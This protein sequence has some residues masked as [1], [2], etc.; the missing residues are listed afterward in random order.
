MVPCNSFYI[1]YGTWR[2]KEV[3]SGREVLQLS[4]GGQAT[5][6]GGIVME[7]GGPSRHH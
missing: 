3:A 7:G 1:I 6:E 4:C 5:K 2:S